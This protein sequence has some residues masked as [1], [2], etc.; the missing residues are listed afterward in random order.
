MKY[1]VFYLLVIIFI[2]SG[3]DSSDT[4]SDTDLETIKVEVSEIK[5]EVDITPIVRNIKNIQLET[6]EECLLRLIR[7]IDIYDNKVFVLDIKDG[8]FVFDFEGDFLYKIGTIGKGPGEYSRAACFALDKKKNQIEINDFSGKLL[9]YS[10]SGDFISER[11]LLFGFRDFEK[12]DYGDYVIN[13]PIFRRNSKNSDPINHKILY[14]N[15][16]DNFKKYRPYFQGPGPNIIISSGGNLTKNKDLFHYIDNDTVFQINREDGILAKYFID[17]GK[18]ALPEKG[19]DIKII[20]QNGASKF[21]DKIGQYATGISDFHQKK[22]F[23]Y[24]KFMY[25][26]KSY[27]VLY[28]GGEV[29]IGTNIKFNNVDYNDLSYSNND[30]LV[31]IGYPLKMSESRLKSYEKDVKEDDNPTLTL[32]YIK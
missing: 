18:Q 28:R 6:S 7:K 2:Y 20:N 31:S 14:G 3:C 5:E 10:I 16:D 11:K 24:F 21:L 27:N 13:R 17:F 1:K 29:N 22:D 19:G 26:K 23:I 25:N 12:D 30:L 4:T 15:F 9:T 32:F 8:L